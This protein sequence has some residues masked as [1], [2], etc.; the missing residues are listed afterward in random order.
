VGL[1]LPRG[2]RALRPTARAFAEC[3]RAY[4]AEITERGIAASITSGD[5]KGGRSDRTGPSA[6]G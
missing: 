3:L 5:S 4:V 1:I 6:R 2:G